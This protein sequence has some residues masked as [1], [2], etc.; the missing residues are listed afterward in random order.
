MG[1]RIYQPM[2]GVIPAIF[3][4][5]FEGCKC[6]LFYKLLC[7]CIPK[8]LL[9]LYLVQILVI[10][11]NTYKAK[12]NSMQCPQTAYL[13]FILSRSQ[14]ALK[15]SQ[16]K[17]S[18]CMHVCIKLY[19]NYPEIIVWLLKRSAERFRNKCDIF[20]LLSLPSVYMCYQT[21]FIQIIISVL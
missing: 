8:M 17:L 1:H 16:W 13:L 12:Q 2:W 3:L 14:W 5:S 15:V 21:A 18:L 9:G 10:L 20:M 6:I 7:K 4:P 11:R 19:K